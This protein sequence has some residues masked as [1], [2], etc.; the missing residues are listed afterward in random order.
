MDSIP[1]SR[2][3]TSWMFSFGAISLNL[4]ALVFLRLFEC[5]KLWTQK[6]VS[7]LESLPPGSCWTYDKISNPDAPCIEDLPT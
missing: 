3:I 4:A 1:N 5:V 6:H 2:K 7:K